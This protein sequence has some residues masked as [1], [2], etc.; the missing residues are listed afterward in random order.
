MALTKEFAVIQGPP[1]TGKTYIGLKVWILFV[2]LPFQ[3]WSSCWRKMIKCS[4]K[5]GMLSKLLFSCRLPMFYC[6]TRRSGTMVERFDLIDIC[7]ATECLLLGIAQS[8]LSVTQTTPLISFWKEFIN[9]I[10]T[11]LC[12]L[13]GGVRVRLWKNAVCRNWKTKCIRWG[14]PAN[15]NKGHSIDR[16]KQEF[17]ENGEIA[18]NSWV[19]LSR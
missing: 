16:T 4:L 5:L 13:E 15:F 3:V 10:P 14:S 17:T 12:E 1:G 6:I 8:L 7:M 18:T 19:T 11:E 2:T 9:S